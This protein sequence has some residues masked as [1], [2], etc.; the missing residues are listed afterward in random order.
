MGWVGASGYAEVE[1]DVGDA[2]GV[3]VAIGGVGFSAGGGDLFAAG[4]L[5]VL[6]RDDVRGSA[7]RNG[8]GLK[9][10]A[11][12]GWARVLIDPERYVVK[13]LRGD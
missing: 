6:P 1:H 11:V 12:G 8:R 10:A 5:R 2:G 13:V 3:A 4:G 9:G 7:G